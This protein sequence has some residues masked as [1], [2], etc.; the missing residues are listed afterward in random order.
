M[1]TPTASRPSA[2]CVVAFFLT[3]AFFAAPAFAQSTT[4]SPAATAAAGKS[5]MPSEEEI[6]KQMME[7][8]Q[9]NENHKLLGTLAG[10]WDY[11]VKM[12]MSPDPKAAP[13][14]AKG[15]A[16][17]KPIMNGRYYIMETGG[18]MQMPGADGKMTDMDF[19]GRSIDGYDNVKKKFVSSWIDNMGTGILLS[20]GTYDAAT[21]TF[22]YRSEGEFMPGMPTKIREVIKVVDGDH[23]TFEWYD[24]ARGA[25]AKTMEIHYTR[26]K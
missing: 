1:K 23:H 11:T 21:K 24:D 17:R 3:L 14:E 5:G 20:E 6:M 26:K 15:T 9:L 16:V 19:E 25:E 4:P 7:L 13:T 8:A 2:V 10:T 18:K 12:W 22:T